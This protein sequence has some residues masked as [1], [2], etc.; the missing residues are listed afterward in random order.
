[1]QGYEC[2]TCGTAPTRV[3]LQEGRCRYCHPRK[4]TTQAFVVGMVHLSPPEEPF[5]VVLAAIPVAQN[6]YTFIHATVQ[7][8]DEGSAIAEATKLMDQDRRF[9][10]SVDGK[11][12]SLV[13]QPHPQP[14]VEKPKT[15]MAMVDCLRGGFS[16]I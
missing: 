16:S 11:S 10:R 12:W 1:M 15:R 14:E 13:D 6:L 4:Q 3:E 9:T 8:D 2:R 7:G 5:F